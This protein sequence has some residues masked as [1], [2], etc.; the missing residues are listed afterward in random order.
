MGHCKVSED[1][2]AVSWALNYFTR[3]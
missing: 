1:V 2:I 3:A